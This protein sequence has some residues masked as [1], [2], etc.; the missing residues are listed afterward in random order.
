M[1]KEE[2]VHYPHLTERDVLDFKEESLW[3]RVLTR[4]QLGG[5]V[6]HVLN[7]RQCFEMLEIP[8]VDIGDPQHSI[9]R[10][11]HWPA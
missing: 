9:Q 6:L 7:C 4:G 10:W 2:E 11:E 3:N 5:I 8:K 1:E